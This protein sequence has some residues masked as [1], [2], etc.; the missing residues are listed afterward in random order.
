MLL[1]GVEARARRRAGRAGLRRPDEV[2]GHDE[3]GARRAGR[4][5]LGADFARGAA[6][7]ARVVEES[8]GSSA[9]RR[10]AARFRVVERAARAHVR[11]EQEGLLAGRKRALA[12]VPALLRVAQVPDLPR[13]DGGALGELG[14]DLVVFHGC[15]CFVEAFEVVQRDGSWGFMVR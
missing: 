13:Y 4:A 10:L 6:A 12:R 15:F 3:P 1:D 5:H 11:H 2:L 8:C 9:G 14:G 7:V